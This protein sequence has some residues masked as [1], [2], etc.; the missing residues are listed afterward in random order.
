MGKA[1]AWVPWEKNMEYPEKRD[2]CD[3][4]HQRDDVKLAFDQLRYICKNAHACYLRWT[5]T[6]GGTE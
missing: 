3:F 4:C 6:H 5:K 2:I 1:P